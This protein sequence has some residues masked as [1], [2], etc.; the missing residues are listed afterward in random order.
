MKTIYIIECKGCNDMQLTHYF[1]LFGSV[2]I[3]FIRTREGNTQKL[4]E[5]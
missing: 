4:W 5:G 1:S 2:T 3:W